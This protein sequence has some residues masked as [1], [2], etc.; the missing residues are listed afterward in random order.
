MSATRQIILAITVILRAF[1]I[2]AIMIG[3]GGCAFIPSSGPNAGRIASQEEVDGTFNYMLVDL[4]KNV[5]DTL[6]AYVS[7][8]LAERFKT[9]TVTSK[10]HT[11]GVGDILNITIFEA[12]P[13]GLFSSDTSRS[14]NFPA[15]QVSENGQ[16]S[17]PYTGVIDVD[18]DTALRVQN[19]IIAR[20]A[21]QAV[22]PQA[23]VVVADNQSNAVVIGG[24]VKNPGRYPLNPGET[25]LLD[26]IAL[27]G[28]TAAPTHETFVTFIRGGTQGRQ[29]LHTI[30]DAGGENIKINAGDR[31]ILRHEPEAF[32]V[33]G[34][35]N[36]PG[37]YPMLSTRTNLLQAIASANGFSD[38]R[39]NKRG[40][41]VF[42]LEP[43][44]IAGHLGTIPP[45]LNGETVPVIYRLQLND[46]VSY[47][48]AT[49]FIIRNKDAIFTANSA[50]VDIRKVLGLFSTVLTPTARAQTLGQGF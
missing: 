22:E 20:L 30:I 47:F 39:A 42:R 5:A 4:D 50:F 31:I 12:G 46:P 8:T 35:V 11:I 18:G 49:N 19:K 40:L 43:R 29:L 26:A 27:A 7:S 32:V 2:L 41:F 6:S 1:F 24:D 28:G 34:A 14:V 36:R 25:T 38:E 10:S 21:G 33:L 3:L 45:E 23:L 9:K 13:G 44:T 16:I 37:N 17:L 15:V 48:V